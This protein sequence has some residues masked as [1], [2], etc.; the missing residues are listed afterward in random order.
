[1]FLWIKSSIK[2]NC[3]PFKVGKKPAVVCDINPQI[4][5]DIRE[6]EI[7]VAVTARRN[8]DAIVYINGVECARGDAGPANLNAKN[9][10]RGR[11]EVEYIDEIKIW[12]V[13]L[14]DEEIR[15]EA[16]VMVDV[17]VSV[18]T[19]KNTY[20]IGEQIRIW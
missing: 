14:S 19:L 17:E 18:A 1:M 2:I 16:G 5:P 8:G 6:E 15:R 4:D 11:G 3:F 9:N 13:V 7:H 20:N 10:F 12:N